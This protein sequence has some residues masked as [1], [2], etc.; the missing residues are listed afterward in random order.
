VTDAAAGVKRYVIVEDLTRDALK[1][2]KALADDER[3]SKVWSIE[4]SIRFIRSND[5]TNT[6][7]RIKSVYDSVE[8]IIEGAK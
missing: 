3:I 7:I 6:V 8:S 1:L 5:K 4:G 2:L